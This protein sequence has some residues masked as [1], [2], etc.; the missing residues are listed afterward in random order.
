MN[1]PRKFRL[2]RQRQVILEELKAVR[3]HPTADEIHQMVRRRLPR[4]S[5][6][7]IYR[8]L[9]MLVECGMIQKL[10]LA[11][12]QGRFDGNAENHYHIRCVHCGQVRD[13]MDAPVAV[14]EGDFRTAT[15]FEI[16]G[17]RLEFV[18][19]CPACKDER[20]AIGT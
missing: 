4:V 14:E 5:L 15:D 17:H 19:L 13:L 1:L 10:E 20:I 3:T 16:L 6:G 2:T 9:E 12:S 7:T 18:G 8:N 11:G